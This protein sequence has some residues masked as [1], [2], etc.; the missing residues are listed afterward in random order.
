[1]LAELRNIGVQLS[2]DDFGTGYSS[3]TFLARFAVDEVKVD[4]AF[5]GRMGES[6]EAAAIVRSTV[7]LGRA[8]G[9]RV[10]AEGVETA[11]QKA[12]LAAMG[13]EAAQGY[14]FFPPLSA[15]K[16]AEVLWSLRRAAEA[17]GANVIPLPGRT[18]AGHPD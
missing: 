5:V 18:Q 12:A 16:A 2:V 10:I 6:P 11:E 17:R 4:Q 9:L 15:D 8:L 3:L 13:C 14:H 7:E 1:V